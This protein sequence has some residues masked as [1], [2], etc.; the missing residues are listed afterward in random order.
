[1]HLW[2]SR[3]TL[4]VQGGWEQKQLYHK[5]KHQMFVLE[6]GENIPSVQER[7]VHSPSH[8]HC[9][10]YELITLDWLAL[11]KGSLHSFQKNHYIRFQ[12]GQ[13]LLRVK[14]WVQIWVT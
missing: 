10:C 7:A 1:M 12:R 8:H 2:R 4:A 3:Q 13:M 6:E 9:C 14:I 5:G 11:E